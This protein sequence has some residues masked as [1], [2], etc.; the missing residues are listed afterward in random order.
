MSIRFPITVVAAGLFAFAAPGQNIC[1]D[2]GL[3]SPFGS[4]ELDSQT[5]N[6]GQLGL[7]R[8]GGEFF[9]SSRGVGAL[10]P[11]LVYV[12]GASGNLV[13][14]FQQPAG[15]S[16]SFWGLRDLTSDGT[17]LFGGDETQVYG[18]DPQGVAV[19]QALA[20]NGPRSL[21][22]FTNSAAHVLVG[23]FRGLAF[24][25]NGNGGNGSFWVASYSS[26][27]VEM[28]LSGA[29]LRQFPNNSSWS[30]YGIAIDAVANSLWIYSQ[31]S[32]GDVVEISRTTGAPTGRKFA[33]AGIEGGLTIWDDGLRTLI[34]RLDQS[35]PD[36]VFLASLRAV[37]TIPDGLELQSQIDTGPYD[38]TFKTM[39]NGAALLNLR[40]TG[41]PASA[42][43]VCFANFG[44]DALACGSL[45]AF[46]PTFAP[47]ADFVA[48]FAGSVPAGF[49]L[50]FALAPNTTFAVP[51][52]L[53]PAFAPMRMQAIWVDSRV[54][55]G[56]LPLVATNEVEIDVDLRAPLGIVVEA[57]GLNSFN[58][59]TT[60]GFFSVLN[61]T[62]TSIT[63]VT[64]TAVGGMLFDP[65]QLG[66]ADRFDGGNSTAVG[67]LGTYR[68][69]SASASGLD[70]ASSPVSP[71]DPAA[72]Q[73]FVS[74]SGDAELVFQFA[75]GAFRNGVKF[76]WDTDT[77]FGAGIDGAA[78]AGMRVVVDLANGDRRSGAFTVDTT[79][80]QRSFVIL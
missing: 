44:P 52:S 23:A 33:A 60:S 35:G 47:L 49:A 45:S 41:T 55:G 76:E 65:D 26:P 70:F 42:P 8:L 6:N 57:R 62:S 53:L 9:V 3:G 28:S 75:G 48:T 31:P 17:N 72:R 24:D 67:C 29:V 25:R 51:A 27:L 12:F 43:M 22:N 1:P 13:R 46:G 2:G 36:R 54:P 38:R 37:N 10:P 32:A 50:D 14:S 77:D 19:T 16:A 73:G 59:I 80:S 71:C 34:A 58:A 61:P 7:E 79:Q 11:H 5:G 56:T 39:R 18:F 30:I 15:T 69:A 74:Q 4:F 40:A 66:M 21:G 63:R 68:N 64:L 78:M 20:A